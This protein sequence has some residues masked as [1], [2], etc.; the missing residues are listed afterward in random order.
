MREKEGLKALTV[1]LNPKKFPLRNE[2][3][4]G[5]TALVSVKVAK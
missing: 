2:T 4:G 5:V 1:K 3:R